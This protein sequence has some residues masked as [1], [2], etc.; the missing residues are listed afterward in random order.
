MIFTKYCTSGIIIYLFVVRMS[1]TVG[2]KLKFFRNRSSISQ[3]DVELGV[4]LA[5]G[6]LSR[7]ESGM[8]NPTKETISRIA[9]FFNLSQTELAYLLDI[10]HT[11][12]TNEEIDEAR[13]S[14]ASHFRKKSTFGYLLDN[15][16]RI[17]DIS[18][19]FKLIGKIIRLDPNKLVGAQIAEIVFDSNYGLRKYIKDF[20]QT[21][22]SVV[23]VLRQ[24][25]EYLLDEPW[26]NELIKRL[27]KLPDFKR[28]WDE[29]SGK[30]F[31][32]FELSSRTVEF[33]LGFKTLKFVYSWTNLP[34]DQRF[35]IVEY[36]RL[37]S[38]A[39]EA[40]E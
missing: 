35:I 40:I 15:K 5:T 38:K 1:K 29:L 20:D 28:L 19:G 36:K 13:R 6:N 22:I 4:G 2:Q 21:A 32:V 12:P 30:E 34:K 9:K 26:W 11:D 25:K 18:D 24:E 3:F 8:I 14:I 16:S 23:A 37:E 39:S 10:N 31:E 7:I 27:M 33:N 17:I